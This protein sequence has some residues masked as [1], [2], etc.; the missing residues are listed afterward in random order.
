MTP[1]DIAVV[2]IL[3]LASWVIGIVTG[4]CIAMQQIKRKR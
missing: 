3:M 2:T 1:L 4:V